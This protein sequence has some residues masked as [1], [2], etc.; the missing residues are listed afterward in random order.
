[1]RFLPILLYQLLW[2]LLHTS[3]SYVIFARPF[4]C[5]EKMLNYLCNCYIITNHTFS[6]LYH[7][8]P[9]VLE[10][11]HYIYNFIWYLFFYH[12]LSTLT[13]ATKKLTFFYPLSF[14]PLNYCLEALQE[15]WLYLFS[16]FMGRLLKDAK[17]PYSSYLTLLRFIFN[18]VRNNVCPHY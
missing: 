8:D 13:M 5:F 2:C 18:F 3:F 14:F 6:V 11:A 7:A 16:V 12:V 17:F 9:L 4:G 10:N 1:M 15:N